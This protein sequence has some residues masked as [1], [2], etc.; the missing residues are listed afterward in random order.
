[1]AAVKPE[2][3]LLPMSLLPQLTTN[4]QE[5]GTLS[6]ISSGTLSDIGWNAEKEGDAEKEDSAKLD[7][8]PKVRSCNAALTNVQ[9]SD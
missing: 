2:L 3:I 7:K 4:I 8:L 6:D 5:S 1:M 9:C